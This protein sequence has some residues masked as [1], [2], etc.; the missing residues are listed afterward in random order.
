K[1]LIAAAE[2]AHAVNHS[3]AFGVHIDGSARIDGRQVMQ[4]VRSERDRFVG[5]VLDSVEAIDSS[6]KLRGHARFLTDTR[7]LV[8]DHT[9]VNAGRVIIATGSSPVIPDMYAD[10]GER[11]VVND[12]VFDWDDLPSSVL[13]VGAGVIGLELGQA[14]ARLGVR[15]TIVNRGERFAGI[16]DPVVRAAARKAFQAELDLRLN[17]S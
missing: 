6:D 15:V 13:V 10:L 17:T 4:R 7:L 11:L 8:D 3:A 9:T 1:L 5:F 14:L 16:S 2:A 12:D